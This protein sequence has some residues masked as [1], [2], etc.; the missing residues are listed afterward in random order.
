MVTAAT[1]IYRYIDIYYMTL[2]LVK[3]IIETIFSIKTPA[4]CLFI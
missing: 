1:S 3:N 4:G 2:D